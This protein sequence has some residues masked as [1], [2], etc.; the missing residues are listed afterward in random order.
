MSRNKTE[1]VK[2]ARKVLSSWNGL[3]TYTERIKAIKIFREDNTLS[4]NLSK[5]SICD[6]FE[7]LIDDTIGREDKND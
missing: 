3:W 1:E 4:Y 5:Q 2:W 6:A 7:W